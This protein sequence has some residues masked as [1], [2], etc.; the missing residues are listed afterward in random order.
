MIRPA[1]QTLQAVQYRLPDVADGAEI[2]RMVRDSGKLD[3]NSPYYYLTMTRWFPESC[4]VA[5]DPESGRLVGVVTGFRQPTNPDTLFIWQIAVDE[6]YQGRGI[7]RNL[8]DEITQHPEI[9]YLEATI[10]PSNRASLRLFSG[11]ASSR[12]IA[13]ESSAGFDETCFPNGEH[14]RE[15]LY[16][17]G[18]LL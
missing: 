15:D 11:W 9:R 17:I 10:S 5:A 16:R 6:R 12:G 3:L 18:P 4:R 8:L 2:W 14:E 13:I 7:A 1:E